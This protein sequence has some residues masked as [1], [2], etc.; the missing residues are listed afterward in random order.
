ME[1]KE[2]WS[3]MC[4]V[5]GGEPD[6]LQKCIFVLM[7]IGL[8][9]WPVNAFTAIYF[10]YIP[11]ISVADEIER[12]VLTSIVWLYPFYVFPLMRLMFRLSERKGASWIFCITPFIPVAVFLLVALMGPS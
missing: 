9:L 7:M 6:F 3:F 1:M 5:L 2:K 12:W 10:F 8:A 4:R 11:T